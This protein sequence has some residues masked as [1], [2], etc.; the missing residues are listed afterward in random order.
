[1]KRA[2][3]NKHATG[4][5]TVAKG[6][7]NAISARKGVKFSDEKNNASNA[8]SMN[9]SGSFDAEDS[10]DDHEA[11]VQNIKESG[12]ELSGGLSRDSGI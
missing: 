5:K 8:S 12:D 10:A 9:A 7:K 11:S 3:D 1:M 4:P 6:K 2:D